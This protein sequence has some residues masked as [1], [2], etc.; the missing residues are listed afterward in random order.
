MHAG[1]R[2]VA[3]KIGAEGNGEEYVELAVNWKI[4][5]EM[6]AT[7][8]DPCIKLRCKTI[9]NVQLQCAASKEP[10]HS[11]HFHLDTMVRKPNESEAV[12]AK[13]REL[14][15]KGWELE[16]QAQSGGDKSAKGDYSGLARS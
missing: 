8:G 14:I 4:V 1:T 2:Y 13:G 3:Y 10:T 9:L 7:S 15:A 5:K 6:W 12:L 16:V 11:C